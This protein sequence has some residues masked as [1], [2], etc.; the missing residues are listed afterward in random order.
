M[1]QR[2]SFISKI[3][4]TN[5]A[6]RVTLYK[7][8]LTQGM[9]VQLSEQLLGYRVEGI[10]HTSIMVHGQE[11]FFD[12]DGIVS[13]IP[14]Q[15]R[16][17]QPMQKID[18]GQTELDFETTKAIVNDLNRARFGPGKYN[19]MN[20]NCN[21]FT[22]EFSNILTDKG[23]DPK[24]LNQAAELSETPIGKMIFGRMNNIF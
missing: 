17:G 2:L 21:H 9:A 20:N 10:W 15:T 16:F 11:F 7:Y 3:K 23:I 8:D 18:L 4:M 19:L 24:I 5:A 22:N 12:A 14:S 6:N 1:G 13:G